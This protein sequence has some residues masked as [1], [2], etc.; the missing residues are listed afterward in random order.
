[1][2]QG[3]QLTEVQEALW[4]HVLSERVASGAGSREY[5]A[6]VLKAVVNEC[7]RTR[8]EVA[9]VLLE[10]LLALR[11]DGAA[12]GKVAEELAALAAV[13][14]DAAGAAPQSGGEGPCDG[15]SARGRDWFSNLF[16][17]SERKGPRGELTD[18]H[19]FLENEER[20]DG[21]V[22]RSKISGYEY[23]VGRFECPSLAELR[24]DPVVAQAKARGGQL[25]LS[26]ECGDVAAIHA[27]P[28]NALATFQ[29][30]S[31][32]NCLEFV[33]P[34]VVPEDGVTGYS[35]DRTQGPACSIA[36][37]PA[38][39]YRNYF[40]RGNGL[41][42]GQVGQSTGAMIDNLADLNRALGNGDGAMMTVRPTST[43]SLATH[44]LI[45]I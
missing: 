9:E 42:A 44:F 31:Q 17:F 13:E 23:G 19:K 41:P 37:G 20:A 38:T 25:R 18:L 33:G 5:V 27:D 14:A 22:M 32:F 35:S 40:V 29:A 34:D 6:K 21:L 15:A 1:V 26:I 36:C 4:H 10:N 2:A 7:D 24:A 30:A 43:C 3:W 8:Q 11:A 39:V 16:H 45:Q 12:G 28:R